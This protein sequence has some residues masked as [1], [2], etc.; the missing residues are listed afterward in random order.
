M[1][2]RGDSDMLWI[3]DGPEQGKEFELRIKNG[4]LRVKI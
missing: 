2:G 4:E 3:M 1:Q